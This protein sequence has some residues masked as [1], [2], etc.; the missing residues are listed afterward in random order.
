MFIEERHKLI[1]ECLEKNGSITTNDIMEQYSVSYDTAKR[2]Y[3]TFQQDKCLQRNQ[4][5]FFPLDIIQ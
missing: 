5:R 2:E 4:N 1:L 3:P